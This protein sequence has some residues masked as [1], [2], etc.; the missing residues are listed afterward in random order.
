[1]KQYFTYLNGEQAGPFSFEQLKSKNLYRDTLVWFEG[2]AEWQKQ[3][4]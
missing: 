4:L 1:M 3:E 2:L